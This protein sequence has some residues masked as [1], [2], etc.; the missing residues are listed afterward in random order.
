MAAQAKRAD[1]LRSYTRIVEAAGP[2]IARDGA[3][4]S[5]EEIARTAGVG[6]ATLHRHFPTRWELLDAVFT[7]RVNALCDDA[8]RS[9]ETKQAGDALVDWLRS[10][11]AESAIN[12]GLAASMFADRPGGDVSDDSCH[13]K[14][15]D[16]GQLLFGNAVAAG[17]VRPDASLVNILKLVSAIV[18][19]TDGSSDA[20][21]ESQA[22]ITMLLEG[23]YPSPRP[24]AS[25]AG[26]AA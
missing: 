21:A 18:I 22:M 3:Q 19:A 5:L 23:I 26:T 4:A 8:E 15:Q 16:A 10:L 17:V 14:I 20:A 13:A 24:P 1:A 12:H 7:D 9:A 25:G 11:T 6:S 2:V